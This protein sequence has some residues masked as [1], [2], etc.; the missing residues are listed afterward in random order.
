MTMNWAVTIRA[1][2]AQRRSDGL[3][4]VENVIC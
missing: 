1:R 4:I 2:A 3:V